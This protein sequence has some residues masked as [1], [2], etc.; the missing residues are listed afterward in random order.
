MTDAPIYAIRQEL[1]A[2]RFPVKKDDLVKK[3]GDVKVG[4]LTGPVPLREVFAKV[5][6]AEFTS[7]DH[8]LRAVADAWPQLRG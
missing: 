8:A 1:M 7:E 4:P 6:A 3:V 5:D 2:L